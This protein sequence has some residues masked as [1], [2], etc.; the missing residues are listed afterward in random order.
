MPPRQDR[1]DAH[2]HRHH[3]RRVHRIPAG[4]ASRRRG[5]VADVIRRN[6]PPGYAEGMQY[7]MIGGASLMAESVLDS[8]GSRMRTA[9]ATASFAP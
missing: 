1:T 2:H 6:L 8:V 3:A 4:R 9:T 7:G 5:A